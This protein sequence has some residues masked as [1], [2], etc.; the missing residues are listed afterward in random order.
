MTFGRGRIHRT[1]CIE[2]EIFKDDMKHHI[3]LALRSY[4]LKDFSEYKNSFDISI[5][6]E[7]HAGFALHHEWNLNRKSYKKFDVFFNELSESVEFPRNEKN[8]YFKTTKRALEQIKK[9]IEMFCTHNLYIWKNSLRK[10]ADRVESMGMDISTKFINYTSR[11]IKR[12]MAPILD[13]I[14]SLPSEYQH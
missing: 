13:E 1:Y 2:R 7:S 9:F 14:S 6:I 5:C 8:V 11:D 12:M 3:Y 4:D 10:E